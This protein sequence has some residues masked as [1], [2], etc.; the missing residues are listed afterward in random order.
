MKNTLVKY[1]SLMVLLCGFQTVFADPVWIDVRTVEEFNSDHIDGDINIPLAELDANKLA[2]RFGKD[3][4]LMVYCRS[5][6]RAG[7]AKT[8]LDAAGFTKVQNAGGI[9]DVR[10]LRNARTLIDL[11]KSS[12]AS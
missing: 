9:G 1:L 4:E 12:P 6:N 8:A 5:G 7:Q 11:A 10:N 3:A 2:A